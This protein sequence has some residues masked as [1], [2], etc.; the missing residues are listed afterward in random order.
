MRFFVAPLALVIAVGCTSNDKDVATP[1]VATGEALYRQPHTDGN[2]FACANCHALNE[3]AEDGRRRA[4]HALADAIRRPAWK[5]GAVA[6][7]REAVN[8]CRVE[9]MGAPAWDEAN[10]SWVALR[11]FLESKAPSGAAPAIT[12]QI[13]APP[14]ALTGGSATAGQTL[15]ND[16]CAECHGTDATGTNRAPR[17]TGLTLQAEY[18]A[19]RIR[20]SGLPTSP[21]YTGLTGGRMPFWGGDRLSDSEL[22]DL[23]AWILSLQSAGGGDAGPRPDSGP[24]DVGNSGC[25]TT[26]ARVGQTATLTTRSHGVRGT[27]R[28]VDDCTIV[29]ENFFFDGAGVDV[30]VYGATGGNYRGGFGMGPDLLR[31][32]GY[33]GETL[34]ASLPAGKTLDNI[35]GISI[36]CVPVGVSFGDGLFR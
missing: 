7:L 17:L 15:F 9:W 30:R 6:S 18:I 28:V 13:V 10:E 27:A 5:N 14:T 3:P 22:K 2:T 12:I 25:G 20:L 16:S 36:W 31:A 33:N 35:D 8:S 4:G 23:V 32:G 19:E 11:E 1:S 29:I 26:H 24:V 21:V 34:T